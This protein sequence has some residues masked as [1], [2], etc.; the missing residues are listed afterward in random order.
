[1]ESNAYH[2]QIHNLVK[3]YSYSF[4]ES[5]KSTAVVLAAG[6]GKRIKSQTSKMLHK[7]WEVPTVNRVCNSWQQCIEESNTILVVGIKADEVIKSVGKQKN[8]SFAYQQ[9]Q[10][11]TGH[12][13]Q[14]GLE[15]VPRDY[16]GTIYVFP[17]DM[18]LIDAETVSFFKQEFEKSG[19][20]MMVLTGIYEGAIEENYYGRIVRVKDK[21]AKGVK[22]KYKGK[23]IEII[24]YKDILQLDKKKA[25]VTKYKKKNF[26][27]T[28]KELLENREFNSGVYAFKAKPLFELIDKIGSNNVQGEVYLTDLIGMFNENGYS[29]EAVTPKN[30]YVL[31]GFNNKS[32]LKEM[33]AIAQKLIY[34]KLKDIILIEDPNDFFIHEEIVDELL[35]LDKRGI[36][37]DI[38]IGKG[39]YIGEGVSLNSNVRLL[40]NVRVEG[41]VS[42]GENVQVGSGSKITSD[43]NSLTKIG[44]NVT[45]KGAC[46]IQ[47]S[48][49]EEGSFIEHSILIKKKVEKNSSVKFYLPDAEIKGSLVNL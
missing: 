2:Q 48:V 25:Y 37:L 12:A 1:M 3:E 13:L 18:G 49:I 34:E 17:G 29:V 4:N 33:D 6:H 16:D 19:A 47:N 20:D 35:E 41:N 8:T 14:V 45:L 43:S 30:Q 36:I 27:F 42:F 46:I 5:N 23:V 11:G 31:M 10:H 38:E 28:Q 24:E 40:R 44:N 39:T 9:V 21:D 32:V 22:S 26:K 15:N 7:I